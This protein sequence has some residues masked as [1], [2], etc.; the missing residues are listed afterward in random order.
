[1]I[2]YYTNMNARAGGGMLPE[3]YVDLGFEI[4]KFGARSSVLRCHCKPVFVFDS[5]S[6][7]DVKMLIHICD[8]YLKISQKRI[9]LSCI[10][11]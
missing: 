1:M 8:N 9:D 6:N 10:K 5:K 2:N 11:A 3:K 4:T 7:V